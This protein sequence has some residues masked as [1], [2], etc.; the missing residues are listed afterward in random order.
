MNK[1]VGIAIL[2]GIMLGIAGAVYINRESIGGGGKNTLPS[3]DTNEIS[4][5]PSPKIQI[6]AKIDGLPNA[7]SVYTKPSLALSV[8]P[9]E[10]VVMVFHSLVSSEVAASGKAF[11]QKVPLKAGYNVLMIGQLGK[12]NDTT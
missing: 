4:Q 1:E 9:T 11:M 12:K 3:M 5:L 7:L 6:L 2:I 8:T 10:D